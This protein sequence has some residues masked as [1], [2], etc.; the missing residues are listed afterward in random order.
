MASSKL[1][2]LAGICRI[3]CWLFI[4]AIPVVMLW[5]LFGPAGSDMLLAGLNQTIR[6]DRVA[7]WQ[8]VCVKLVAL[9]P[10]II[11]IA[12]IFT[13]QKTFAAFQRGTYFSLSNVNNIK[14]L[15][16]YLLINAILSPL[17]YTLSLLIF[18]VSQLP[19][20]KILSFRFGS[21]EI[22]MIF[23]AMI[24]WVIAWVIEQGES[25]EHEN[26]QFI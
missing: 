24:F 25:I 14:R 16:V 17:V 4:V 21:P 19:G 3:G 10:S 7:P 8:W 12:G 18:S 26:R 15:S 13:L 5:Y 1:A 22:K 11:L 9:L 6:V 2:K 23:I 20:E